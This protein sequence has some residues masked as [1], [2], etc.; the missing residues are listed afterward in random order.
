MQQYEEMRRKKATEMHYK[1]NCVNNF[2]RKVDVRKLIQSYQKLHSTPLIQK[3]RKHIIFYKNYNLNCHRD[4]SCFPFFWI[5]IPNKFHK[6]SNF[7][8]NN[9]FFDK[10]KKKV[11][12]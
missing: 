12:S 11:I 4:N 10:A 1:N 6:N 5:D 2:E 7:C 8:E 9:F 3:L